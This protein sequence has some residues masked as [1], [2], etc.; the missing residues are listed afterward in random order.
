[1]FS[2]LIDDTL[3][4]IKLAQKKSAVGSYQENMVLCQ[5]RAPINCWLSPNKRHAVSF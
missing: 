1:M 5:K 4:I 2:I 3:K